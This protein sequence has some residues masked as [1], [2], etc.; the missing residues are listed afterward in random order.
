MLPIEHLNV[1]LLR[2]AEFHGKAG[3]DELATQTLNLL[4][5]RTVTPSVFFRSRSRLISCRKLA[6]SRK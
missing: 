6:D 3:V 2:S 5:A 1:T 4:N